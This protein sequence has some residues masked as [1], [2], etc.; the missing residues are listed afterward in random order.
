MK[1]AIGYLLAICLLLGGC[2]Q[3]DG[4][5]SAVNSS[6]PPESQSALAEGPPK[7][8]EESLPPENPD[9]D[10][11]NVSWGMSQEE[12]IAY[13]GEI[14]IYEVPPSNHD[15]GC[16]GLTVSGK[17]ADLLYLFNEK[18]QLYQTMYVFQIDHTNDTRYIDDFEDLKESLTSLYGAPDRDEERWYNDLFKG[19]PQDYGTAIAAGHLAYVAQ[20]YLDDTEILLGLTGDNY[21]LTLV[22]AYFS[23]TVPEPQE[24]LSGL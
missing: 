6:S 14:G 24:D 11:R 20:W 8:E 13:E 12:V 22:L 5:A 17:Q 4:S 9:A 10:F 7:P 16:T 3:G 18:D 2:A 19:Q 15:L 21:E 23:T 1:Q